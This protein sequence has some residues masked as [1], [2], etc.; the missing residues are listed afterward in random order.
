MKKDCDFLTCLEEFRYDKDD[1]IAVIRSV[2][3]KDLGLKNI[4]NFHD[5]VKDLKMDEPTRIEIL[6][7]IEHAIGFKLENDLLISI[8][9]IDDAVKIYESL[10]NSAIKEKSKIIKTTPF[11]SQKKC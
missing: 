3:L 5:F 11:S 6:L 1:L 9:S 7:A 10:L 2:I 8:M 4:E